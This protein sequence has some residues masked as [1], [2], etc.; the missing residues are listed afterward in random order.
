MWKKGTG[1]EDF[2]VFARPRETTPVQ[3]CYY[4]KGMIQRRRYIRLIALMVLL[5]STSC[6]FR[7]IH[8]HKNITYMERDEARSL[9]P[10]SLNVFSPRKTADGSVLIFIH[11]GSWRSGDKKL[12][13]F[14]GSRMARKGIVTVV[15]GYPLN[16]S[17]DFND[18]ANA[19]ARSVKWVQDNIHRFGGDP[20]R[21]FL[22]GHSAG[23]HLAALISVRDE[24]LDSAGVNIPIKGAILIDAA[25]LDMYGYLTADKKPG[26]HSYL[27]TFT[28]NPSEWKKASPLYYVHPNMPPFLIYRGDRTYPSIIIGNEKFRTALSGIGSPVIYTVQK[29]KKHVP[30]IIQFF[31]TWNP[32]YK[33]IRDF[34]NS[35]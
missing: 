28:T 10:Q 7:S 31:W 9:P 22:S 25:G 35:H 26:G 1:I 30:M 13:N 18:M 5:A 4:L 17:G 33:E 3:L 15:I 32:R 27:N 29:R 19:S 20:S 21:V 34:I 11:G 8:R 2:E 6:A 16:P 24:Y 14:L 23:G 12:Y